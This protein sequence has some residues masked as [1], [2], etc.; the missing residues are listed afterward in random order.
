M[1]I[2]KTQRNYVYALEPLD[3]DYMFRTLIGPCDGSNVYRPLPPQPIEQYQAAVDWAVSMAD[4]F[5]HPIHI[6]PLDVADCMDLYRE[7][8]ER[9][10][11]ALTPAERHRMRKGMVA[12]MAEVMR[13]CPD[14]EVRAEAYDVL[15]KMRVVQPPDRD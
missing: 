11:A 13:D 2:I 10:L 6:V 7:Q 15:T 12:A 3:R 1:A 5:E 9:G 14:P 4:Q 8:M